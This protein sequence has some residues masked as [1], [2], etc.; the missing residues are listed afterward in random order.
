[1]IRWTGARIHNSFW[2]E[3]ALRLHQEASL[4]VLR[5]RYG[6]SFAR[7]RPQPTALIGNPTLRG[8]IVGNSR[9]PL[10]F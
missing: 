4:A 1:M 5:A 7:P 10:F 2:L 3:Y 8:K 6:F 9:E